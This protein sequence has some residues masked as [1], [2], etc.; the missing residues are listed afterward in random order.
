MGRVALLPTW[1][2]PKLSEMGVT[3][4]GDGV[5]MPS[6]LMNSSAVLESET[7]SRAEM[8]FVVVLVATGCGEKAMRMVQLCE[9]T[10]VA[11]VDWTVKSGMRWMGWKC[12]VVVPV[13]ERVT[14]WVSVRSPTWVGPKV[15][16]L[17]ERA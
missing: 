2:E 11:Q 10:S 16:E 1:T 9:G 3:V 15:R 8:R 5:A 4:M 6:R 14:V 7:I 13:L 12:R 17:C